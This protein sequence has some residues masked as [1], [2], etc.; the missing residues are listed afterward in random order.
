M[1]L[2]IRDPNVKHKWF[3][4]DKIARVS[5]NHADYAVRFKGE[6]VEIYYKKD[7]RAIDPLDVDLSL[8]PVEINEDTS[9]TSICVRFNVPRDEEWFVIVG[10]EAYL[11]NDEG[12]T[13]EKIC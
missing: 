8:I 1:I 4:Y 13:I 11:L 12:T 2:K 6:D 5:V 9:V 10:S 3:F 7:D